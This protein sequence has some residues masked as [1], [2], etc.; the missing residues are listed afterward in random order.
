MKVY[1]KEV[2][3]F[4]VEVSDGTDRSVVTETLKSQIRPQ[5]EKIIKK[6]KFDNS[7]RQAFLRITGTPV[8]IQLITQ[9]QFVMNTAKKD[10]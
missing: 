10:S 3:Y 2:V 5:F 7:D 1:L 9:R 6:I 8:K 4:E